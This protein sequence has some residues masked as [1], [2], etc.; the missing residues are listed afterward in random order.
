[1]NA[2]SHCNWL[3]CR[4]TFMTETYIMHV[5]LVR[6]VISLLLLIVWRVEARFAVVLLCDVVA[7]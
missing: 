2:G 3:Y 7:D 6:Y 1:M 4:N 5:V